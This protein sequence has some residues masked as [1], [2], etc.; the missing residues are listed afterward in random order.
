[1]ELSIILERE[2]IRAKKEAQKMIRAYLRKWEKVP[3]WVA[4]YLSLERWKGISQTLS[5]KG[6]RGGGHI[7]I[8]GKRSRL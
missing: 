6:E 5:G 2:G 8:E 4:F 7:V 1:M 3:E